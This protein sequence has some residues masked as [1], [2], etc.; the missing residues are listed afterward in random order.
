MPGRA[1]TGRPAAA[2]RAVTC[3]TAFS[4]SGSDPMAAGNGWSYA[5]GTAGTCRK[6]LPTAISHLRV[7]PVSSSESRRA[8][9]AT[10]TTRAALPLLPV[11]EARMNALFNPPDNEPIP[12]TTHVGRRAVLKG[13]AATGALTVPGLGVAACSSSSPGPSSHKSAPTIKKGGTLRVAL[14]GGSSSDT[15]DA[16]S[17]ITTLDFAPIF[18]LDEPLIAIGPNAHPLPF[19]AVGITPAKGGVSRGIQVRPA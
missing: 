11:S 4:G 12:A 13:L 7:P 10:R 18:Q 14:S 5:P 3:W 9:S 2:T 15:P 16:P 17:A 6:G 19:V 1:A 8:S